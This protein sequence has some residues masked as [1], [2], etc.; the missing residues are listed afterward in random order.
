MASGDGKSNPFGNGKSGATGNGS[1]GSMPGYSDHRG[2]D[3]PQKMG[4]S[5]FNADSVPKGGRVLK[6]DPPSDRQGLVG[7][8]ATKGLSGG[9]PFKINGGPAMPDSNADSSEGGPVGDIPNSDSPEDT[10]E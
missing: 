6:L 4:A 5:N 10:T 1:G 3:R 9:L 7:Q 2:P 8:T